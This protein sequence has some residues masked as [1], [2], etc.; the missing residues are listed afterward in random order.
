M[1]SRAKCKLI[2]WRHVMTSDICKCSSSESRAS[3]SGRQSVKQTVYVSL[4]MCERL[5]AWMRLRVS[6]HELACICACVCLHVRICLHVCTCM[7]RMYAYVCLC[8]RVGLCV[9]GCLGP[10]G[11]FSS[12]VS[13]EL[14]R[15]TLCVWTP[16]KSKTVSESR[17][18]K[19]NSRWYLITF[20]VISDHCYL[21][22]LRHLLSVCLVF[23][24]ELITTSG[25]LT[26]LY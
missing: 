6:V 11:C 1:R 20:G 22:A 4:I 14:I 24:R 19:L 8:A 26:T 16:R 25:P 23:P 17:I 21:V 7:F 3:G 5:S 2:D 9:R 15:Q 10:V 12:H 13:K 18:S